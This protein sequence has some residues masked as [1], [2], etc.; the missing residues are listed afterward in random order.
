MNIIYIRDFL[1]LS[2]VKTTETYVRMDSEQ[3]RKA[4]EAA[5]AD[6][7]PQS[8]AIEI[9]NDDEKLLNW[10]KGLGK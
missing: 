7:I 5:A 4:L 10:L 6:I 2:S 8:Q 3:K 9:W 1:G